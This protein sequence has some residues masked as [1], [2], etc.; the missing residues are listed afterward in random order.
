MFNPLK[1]FHLVEHTYFL[2][3]QAFE[4]NLNKYQDKYLAAAE[5]CYSYCKQAGLNRYNSE[6]DP[7]YIELRD[8]RDAAYHQLYSDDCC[9]TDYGIGPSHILT[10]LIDPNDNERLIDWYREMEGILV[11]ACGF[12]YV[13]LSET[14]LFKADTLAQD[15]SDIKDAMVRNA[16]TTGLTDLEAL[17]G[18]LAAE[19]M[20]KAIFQALGSHS[21]IGS[22]EAVGKLLEFFEACDIDRFSQLEVETSIE[23]YNREET[24]AE[25]L[26]EEYDALLAFLRG[27]IDRGQDLIIKFGMGYY[28]SDD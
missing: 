5:A 1:E 14:S 2:A 17:E 10:H 27:L 15:R 22:P 21:Y 18:V 25:I 19:L 12:R 24:T 9:Y 3:K 16:Q 8:K 6:G 4:G 11:V 26:Q 20:D 23:F 7:N 28:V 13:D